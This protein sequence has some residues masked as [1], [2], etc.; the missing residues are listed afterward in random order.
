LWI[1]YLQWHFRTRGQTMPA[2]PVLKNFKN[3]QCRD[4][5]LAYDGEPQPALDAAGNAKSVWDRLGKKTDTVT[6]RAV[7]DETRRVPLLTYKN[8]KQA[9]WPPADFI[10][11]NPPFIGSWLMRDDLGDGYAETLR[12]AYPEVPESANFVMY[13]WHKAAALVSAGKVES[14]GFITTNALRQTFNRRV[15]QAHLTGKRP[16]SLA[17][18]IPDH[19]WVNTADG[20]AVRIAM[21]VGVPGE[22]A[23]E[24]LEVKTETTQPD[25][26]AKVTF[27]SKRGKISADLTISTNLSLVLP[28]RANEELS[29]HGVITGAKGFLVSEEQAVQ[30]GYGR[31]PK[32]KNVIRILRN[33][34]D[35][36]DV[37]RDMFVLDLFGYSA[38]EVRSNFPAIYQWLL[39]NVKPVRDANRRESRRN[40]W[41]LFNESVP[42]LRRMLAGLRRYIATVE[43][44]KHRIFVFLDES[45]LPAHKLVNI[46]LADAFYLG[47]LSSRIHVTFALSR[48]ALVGPTPVYVKS[49]C[50]EPFP[51]PLCGERE[52]ARIRELA[53]ALDAHRKQVQAKHG[54]TLTGLYNVLEKIRAG[55]TLTEK[56]KFVHDRGLVST[57]KSLHD[58]LDAAV[59]AAYGWPASLTDAEILER[60]VALNA[61][62]AA[63][64]S[65]GVIH[66]LR[67]EYQ[68]KAI[69]GTSYT[70]PTLNLPESKPK[71]SK[72]SGTR[73]TR[74]SGKSAW[75]KTLPERMHVVETAL[76]AAAVPITPADLAKQ[77]ARAKPADVTEIL[78]TLETFGRARNAGEGKFRT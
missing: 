10:V 53:E 68:S 71:P 32:V 26:S 61:E 49:D 74:P 36:T 18:A 1:G 30:L 3:I 28:L 56:E 78:K 46:A 65:R 5:V 37:S 58:D 77:F 15:V 38:E 23:G 57:L 27:D 69:G 11:G 66:W 50:F 20:A 43:T 31:E 22:H 7:P 24:L 34:E 72:K 14:F 35:L 39:T 25:G 21:T 75:P 76:H 64:E 67:P 63:G 42:K 12:A 9:E 70:S 40:N 13:W 8:P 19:P 60:L 41:W 54:V 59:S 45:I 17:F 33:G 29:N 2:E 6:G 47:V 55:A 44:A 73:G 52:K 62:R 51:F 16:L 48:R 4:A